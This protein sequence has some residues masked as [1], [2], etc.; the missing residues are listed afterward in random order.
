MDIRFLACCATTGMPKNQKEKDFKL[1]RPSSL[2]CLNFFK[3]TPNLKRFY[4]SLNK[5]E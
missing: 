2:Y 1:Q 3:I 5:A 4:L